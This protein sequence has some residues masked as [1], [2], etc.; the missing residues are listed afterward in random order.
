MKKIILTGAT[1]PIGSTIYKKYKN[2]Y[3]IVAVSK[4]LGYDLQDRYNQE[5]LIEQTKTAFA[6]I[7]C[8]YI[9]DLQSMFLAESCAE[10]NISFGS[11]I[12][13]VPWSYASKISNKTYI[14]NKLFLEYVHKSKKN[15]AL[16]SIS[17]FGPNEIVPNI[18]EDQFLNPITDILDR[19]VELPVSIDIHNG[20]G[21]IE[22][23]L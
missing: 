3:E 12:T 6:F 13:K 11:L 9:D 1:S 14:K 17:S 4:S 19:N 21:E 8:A 2:N 23:Y 10:I 15:S 18:R 22:A 5:H 7:N 16:I 20:L